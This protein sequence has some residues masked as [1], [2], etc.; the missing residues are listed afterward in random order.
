MMK[1]RQC[2]QNFW[3]LLLLP[4][5][6]RPTRQGYRGPIPHPLRQQAEFPLYLIGPFYLTAYKSCGKGLHFPRRIW[7]L[8]SFPTHP[9]C[10]TSPERPVPHPS[11]CNL[12]HLEHSLVPIV[13]ATRHHG[14]CLQPTDDPWPNLILF[15]SLPDLACA[16]ST[17]GD[18]VL[19]LAADILK[20]E[21]K[22][23]E[24]SNLKSSIGAVYLTRNKTVLGTEGLPGNQRLSRLSPFVPQ[25]KPSAYRILTSCK[26]I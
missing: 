26:W 13:L 4:T 1:V 19:S 21:Q 24:F 3:D 20:G 7:T 10:P 15:H 8:Y 12:R 17:A 18:S 22:H 9:D 16:P 14:Q 6:S 2:F 11:S 5:V 25:L 23:C